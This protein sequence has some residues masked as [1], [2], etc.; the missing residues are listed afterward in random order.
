[1]AHLSLYACWPEAAQA[2]GYPVV[3]RL[4]YDAGM[5]IDVPLRDL[6]PVAVEPLTKAVLALTEDDWRAQSI[7]QDEYEVH[8]QTQSIVLVFTDGQ[9]WPN[10]EVKK[11]AGWDLLAELA[12]PLIH[13]VLAEH[14]EPG[15]TIIRAMAARLPADNIIKPHVDR[16]PS[17]HS[18]HRIHVPL[19]TNSRVRFMIDGRPY[20]LVV[21]RAYELNN[22]KNHSVMNK[23][24]QDRIT[25]IFDYLPAQVVAN[26][27]R[28]RADA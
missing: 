1:M 16:H 12:M 22:Q 20:R 13:N 25:L 27:D 3:L 19:T 6:G 11:E 4:G 28:A 2:P 8:R 24:S 17:F 9:G 23:G 26:M 7:R 18:S 14:Y 21:G 15:G 5:D 10:I